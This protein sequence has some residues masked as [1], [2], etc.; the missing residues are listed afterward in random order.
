MAN[1]FKNKSYVSIDQ[2]KTKSQIV[3]LFDRADEMKRI[4]ENHEVY[5][6]LKGMSIAI[7]FYQPSTRTFTSFVAAAKRLGAYVTSIHG[8]EQFSS[9]SKGETLEDTI[10]SIHQTTAADAIIIRHPDNNS[11]RPSFSLIVK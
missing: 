5:E 7:L 9:V 3:S 1:L 6:P 8:M 2:V 4:V 11:S 10:R